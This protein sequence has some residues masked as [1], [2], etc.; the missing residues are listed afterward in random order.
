MR[1]FT[2]SV[3]VI[4]AATLILVATWLLAPISPAQADDARPR[5]GAGHKVGS[6]TDTTGAAADPARAAAAG[7]SGQVTANGDAVAGVSIQLRQYQAGINIPVLTTTTTITG[8]FVFANPAT[9]PEGWTYYAYYGPNVTNP[10]YVFDWLGPDIVGYTEGSAAD[11][12]ILDIADAPLLGPPSGAVLP[13][14]PITFTYTPRPTS[15]TAYYVDLA[16]PGSDVSVGP[17]YLSQTPGK[18]VIRE[19]SDIPDFSPGAVYLWQ[20]ILEDGTRPSSYGH[21]FEVRRVTLGL[22]A[23]QI[24]LPLVAQG[25]PAPTPRP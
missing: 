16:L 10:A 11:A 22:A 8:H 5:P 15:N 2:G 17:P 6:A 20:L 4:I 18:V 23:H 12:G 25:E 3:A 9:P 1:P 13:T 19:A 7:I 21:S 24:Y 14:F